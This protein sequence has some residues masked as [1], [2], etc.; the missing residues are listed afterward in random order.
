MVWY[1]LVWVGFGMVLYVLCR[2]F[3]NV[4]YGFGL[5]RVGIGMGWVG[6][7]MGWVWYGLVLCMNVEYF[8]IL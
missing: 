2:M 5:I 3:W 1:V 7:V 4:W 8:R 6:F